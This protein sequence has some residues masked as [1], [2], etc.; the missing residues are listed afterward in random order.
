[1]LLPAVLPPAP[2][3]DLPLHTLAWRPPCAVK[4]GAVRLENAT[5]SVAGASG[6][7]G[8]QVDGVWGTVRRMKWGAAGVG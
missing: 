7:L 8:V 4:V 3:S 2:C 5:R 1:M 6:R